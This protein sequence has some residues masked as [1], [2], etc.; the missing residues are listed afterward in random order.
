MHIKR[1]IFYDLKSH[2]SRKEI[3]MIVGPRQCGKTTTMK[4]LVKDLKHSGKQTLFLNLDSEQDK[5][6]LESQETLISKLKLEFGAK[7][8]YVFIDEIQRKAHAGLFLKGLYDMD[9]GYKFIVSG[10]GN[11][12]IKEK[13]S[14]S[15]MGR[16][17]LFKML[18]VGFNE[19][20]NF[21]TA[22]K[23]EH[24]LADYFEIENDK[25]ENLLLEYLNYGGYPRIVTSDS[26][27]EKQLEMAEIYQSYINQDIINWLKVEKIESFENLIKICSY[28]IGNLIDYSALANNTNLSVK[29]VRN[30]I[31]YLRKTFILRKCSP[32]YTNKKTEIIKSPLFYFYDLGL[33]NYAINRFAMVDELSN[34]IGF[35]FENFIFNLL[36][37]NIQYSNLKVNFWRS[38]SH[39]EV[40]FVIDFGN[41]LVPIEVKFRHYKKPSVGKSMRSF[42]KKY[43]PERAYLVNRS[44][45]E[46]V[47]IDGSEVVFIP[48]WRIAEVMQIN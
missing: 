13:I 21:K 26:L 5:R 25:V 32:F 42:I 12:E 15:L 36:N 40:D 1:N 2:L 18:P 41:R 19:F 39:A 20:V 45:S 48:F 44:F 3:T 27:Q 29:T 37:E 33:R 6:Y 23:Y 10:S 14:E 28:Q 31:W 43:R 38:K 24:R 11:V 35:L 30:Y 22:Y 9:L 8:G 34:D 47:L 16:K 17:R 7:K 4:R 46:K